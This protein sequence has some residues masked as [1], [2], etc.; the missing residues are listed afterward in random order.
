MQQKPSFPLITLLKHGGPWPIIPNVEAWWT[1]T[2]VNSR[3]Q[4]ETWQATCNNL[5][6]RS[7]PYAVFNLL[8]TVSSK[9]GSSCDPEFSNS[10]SLK[11]TANTYASYL[12]SHFSQQTPQLSCDTESSFMNNL[13]SDQCSNSTL[14]STF[15]SPF[16]T[17]ELTTA[18]SKL[19][20]S[21][22]LIS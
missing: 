12:W 13:R 11:D 8:N 18:I 21:T 9:K 6:P 16:T 15:C 3:A 14:H 5:S 19:S 4:A 20:T 10:Q 17:K 22:A 7:N 2:S 1:A